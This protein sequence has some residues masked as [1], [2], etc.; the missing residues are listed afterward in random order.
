MLRAL[1]WD[2]ALAGW[3]FLVVLGCG[4]SGSVLLGCWCI[5]VLEVVALEVPLVCLMALVARTLWLLGVA[6]VACVLAGARRFF[7]A[8]APLLDGLGRSLEV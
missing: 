4:W 1:C 6:R 5:W 3:L 2:P 7:D 8:C